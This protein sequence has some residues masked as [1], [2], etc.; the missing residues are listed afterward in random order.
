MPLAVAATEDD[1]AMDNLGDSRQPSVDMS[2]ERE[3]TLLS[4]NVFSMS[5]MRASRGVDMHGIWWLGLEARGRC[6][7]QT[8]ST[9][10]GV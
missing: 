9:E 3:G 6:R 10:L 2:H 4:H 5:K 1:A 8:R 7:G